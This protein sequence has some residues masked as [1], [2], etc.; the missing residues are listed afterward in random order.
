[1][2]MKDEKGNV[3]VGAFD[4]LLHNPS[5]DVFAMLDYKT[6][7][8][9]P[10]LNYCQQYYQNQAD[11]YTRFLEIGG[12]KVAPFAVLLYFWP[13][14]SETL[15]DFKQQAFL[16]TPNTANAEKIF[17]DAIVCLEGPM[18]A[19]SVDC[20]YCKYGLMFPREEVKANGTN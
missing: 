4:D 9:Q 20:E 14:E 18:P 19:P 7:G 3:L 5:A 15:I 16:L 1:M 13:I 6:K 10:D 8:S 11:I 2:C 17:K 12:K